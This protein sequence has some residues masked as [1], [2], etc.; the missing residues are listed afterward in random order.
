MQGADVCWFCMCTHVH[1]YACM[2]TLTHTRRLLT[3]HHWLLARRIASS[4]RF[5]PPSLLAPAQ[6]SGQAPLVAGPALAGL[7]GGA[8]EALSALPQP[9]APPVTAAALEELVGGRRRVA[10][11]CCDCDCCC[12]CC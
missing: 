3:Q 10:K 11:A 4:L 7:E 5:A 8:A 9:A 1:T 12:C 6:D 2:H